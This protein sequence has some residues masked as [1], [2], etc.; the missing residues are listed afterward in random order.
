[1]NEAIE[2]AQSELEIGWTAIFHTEDREDYTV[3]AT[4]EYPRSPPNSEH[5]AMGS[6]SLGFGPVSKPGFAGIRS[7]SLRLQ[8]QEGTTE[9]SYWRRIGF[10]LMDLGQTEPYGYAMATNSSLLEELAVTASVDAQLSWFP[11]IDEC[12]GLTTEL[13][14]D[15]HE[16]GEASY[17]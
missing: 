13:R 15:S 4:A 8:D 16:V 7:V 12:A 14:E 6:E 2:H 5:P 11:V 10:E 1:M 3:S 17:P 9:G